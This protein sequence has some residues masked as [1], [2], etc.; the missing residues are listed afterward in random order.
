MSVWLGSGAGVENACTV[1]NLGQ[2]LLQ[3]LQPVLLVVQPNVAHE[4]LE[5][6]FE[7]V[8]HSQTCADPNSGNVLS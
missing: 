7:P 3:P 1:R 6:A 4:G 2:S 5:D 8:T